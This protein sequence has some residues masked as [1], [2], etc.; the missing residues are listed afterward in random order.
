MWPRENGRPGKS[1]WNLFPY[2]QQLLRQISPTQYEFMAA[3]RKRWR[4]WLPPIRLTLGANRPTM[5]SVMLRLITPKRDYCGCLEL[6]ATPPPTP[7]LPS[8]FTLRL[9][10]RIWGPDK[11]RVVPS[12]K[13]VPRELVSQTMSTY[14]ALSNLRPLSPIRPLSDHS[15]L[16]RSTRIGERVE[17]PF[18]IVSLIGPDRV[19][20]GLH[21]W[22]IP[23]GSF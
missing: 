5:V 15:T 23:S 17:R 20:V 13:W 7:T 3:G 1:E 6:S 18:R 19:W 10:L 11:V 22:D 4:S 14:P 9:L 8:I 21:G 2:A 12:D 16:P